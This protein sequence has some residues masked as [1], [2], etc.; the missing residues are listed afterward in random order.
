MKVLI[1]GGT[2]IISSAVS[3]ALMAAGHELWLINRGSN[4]DILPDNTHGTHLITA[5]IN[6][7]GTIAAAIDGQQFDCI[8][9]FI[10]Q[11]PEQIERDY[12]LFGGRTK[13]YIFISSASAYQKPLSH[14]EITESTPLYNPYWEYPRNKIACEETLMRIYRETGFPITIIRP[15]H[16]Y[17]E[18]N[19]PLCITGFYGGYSVIQ[20]MLEEKPTIIPGDGTSLWTLT[21]NSDFARAFLGI[22]GNP[23]AIGEAVNITSDEVMTWNQIYESIADVLSVPL[24][25]F[26]VSSMFLHQAGP[27]D[28][29]CCL[30]GERV[31]S[32]IFRNDKLKRLVPGFVPQ[33]LFRDGIRKT[34]NNLLSNPVLQ[35]ADP[36]FD[37]WCDC[38][39]VSLDHTAA[40]LKSSFPDYC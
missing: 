4:N 37:K 13:Q 11:K 1:I 26:Y 34:L 7:T 5:D 9:D 3:K 36:I 8:A 23:R 40:R 16:T 29:K 39:A 22:A 12:R 25:P 30:I 31:Q 14:Y 15:S 19:V 38:L 6:D 35:V 32:A 10:V 2:G 17:D 24:H 20:R 28:L 18:N 33:V 27:Y 21:H